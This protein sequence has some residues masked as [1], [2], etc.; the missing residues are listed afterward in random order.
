MTETQHHPC[1]ECGGNCCRWVATGIR[2]CHLLEPSSLFEHW[3]PSCTNGRA[4]RLSDRMANLIAA[5]ESWPELA[6]QR[7]LRLSVARWPAAQHAYWCPIRSDCPC[8]CN[9]TE[10]KTARETARRL[11][12]LEVEP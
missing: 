12:G 6:R 5:V 1:P 10:V 7:E 11:V 2:S 4:G 9:Y 3:C 8:E